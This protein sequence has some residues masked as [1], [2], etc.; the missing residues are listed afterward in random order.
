MNTAWTAT[1]EPVLAE[2]SAATECLNRLSVY[3]SLIFLLHNPL[4]KVF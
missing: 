2:G 3:F 1:R 4:D